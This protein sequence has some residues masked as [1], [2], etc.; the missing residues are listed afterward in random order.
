MNTREQAY[1]WLRAR[2]ATLPPPQGAGEWPRQLEISGGV[3]LVGANS[4]YCWFLRPDGELFEADQDSVVPRLERVT[5][6]D[7]RRSVLEEAVKIMPEL[8]PLLDAHEASEGRL[9][10]LSAD[11]RWRARVH[12]DVDAVGGE[13]TTLEL[14]DV[15]SGQRT[16]LLDLREPSLR[17]VRFLEARRLL[18]VGPDA[19]FEVDVDAPKPRHRLTSTPAPS[20]Q[21]P[22]P[23][24]VGELTAERSLV[25]MFVFLW[26]AGLTPLLPAVMVLVSSAWPARL[27]ALALLAGSVVV[28]V[29]LVRLG[30]R[31]RVVG[32][33][34]DGALR[35]SWGRRLP[36][37]MRRLA[38]DAID[39]VVIAREARFAVGARAAR[40][41]SMSARPDR[42]RITARFAKGRTVD[43]GTT[44][45]EEE[46]ATVRTRLLAWRAQTRGG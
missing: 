17:L 41:P 35:V 33:T 27:Q 36:L 19:Q 1:A 6:A 46:A 20:P 3:L 38:L 26:L 43:V 8:A 5:D 29:A 34:A 45:T 37:P 11:G 14:F 21:P 28:A 24:Y 9:E 39:D 10:V 32:I 44:A 23:R 40:A 25:S 15:H 4:A 2:I 42:W 12:D 7:R 31:P 22:E 30:Q 18:L 13:V 16:C